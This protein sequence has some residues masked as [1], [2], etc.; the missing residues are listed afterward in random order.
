[1]EGTTIATARSL[2][3]C[4]NESGVP[5]SLVIRFPTFTGGER[6]IGDPEY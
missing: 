2:I 6:L 3:R 5:S 4:L 1:M